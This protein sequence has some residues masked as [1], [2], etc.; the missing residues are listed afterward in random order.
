MSSTD[1]KS[2]SVS[3]TPGGAPAVMPSAERI[4]LCSDGV[5]GMIDDAEI[6]KG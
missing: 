1:P 2:A 4:V 6:R 3:A 5:N